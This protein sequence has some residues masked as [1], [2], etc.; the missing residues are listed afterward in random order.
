MTQKQETVKLNAQQRAAVE[1]G[2]GPL[3]IVAGAG[4]GKTRV[5]VERI[6]S[7]LRTV[8]G[9]EPQQI[10]ALTFT[11]R[12]AEQM[13]QRAAERFGEPAR[14]CRF[15]TFHAFCYELLA[16][17]GPVRALDKIDEWI[18]LR[19]HLEELHLDYYFK[20]SDPGR[21][22]HD[23]VDFCSRCH[24]NLVSPSEY[25]DYVE[26]LAARCRE[27]QKSGA[28]SPDCDPEALARQGEVAR[29]FTVLERLQQDQGLISYGAMISRAIRLLDDSPE[30][31]A[32]LQDQYQF[33][34]V[35]EFQDVNT[36]QFE[37]LV[38]LAG[39][40]KNLT[41]VGD[42][43]QA[44]YRFR[45][46]SFASF[47]QFA[48]QFPEHS[49]IVLDR[50]YRSTQ[51]ILTVAG[52]A[53]AF[54]SQDRYLPEKKLIAENDSGPA[55]EMWEF[56]DDAA[57]ADSTAQRIAASVREGARK[58]YSDFAVLYRA[59]LHRARLVQAL[60][61]HGVPFAIQNLAIHRLPII[62]DLIACLRVIGDP[63]DS[64]SLVRLLSHR[65]WSMSP[66]LLIRQCREAR[67]RKRS[68][69]EWIEQ[70]GV[71]GAWPGR[72]AFLEFRNRF[73]A[74]AKVQ[75]LVEWLPLLLTELGAPS[76][77][78]EKRALGAFS[79]FVSQWNREKSASGLLAEFLVYLA[80][81]EEAGGAIVLPDEAPSRRKHTSEAG[82]ASSQLD[83]WAAPP[84]ID[85]RGRVQLMTLHGAKGLEFEHVILWHLVKRA[86][87]T[88]HRRPLIE[89]PPALWKGPLPR[90]DFHIEEERRLFYVGLTRARNA[91]AL[92]TISNARQRPS[93]FLDELQNT[94][95]P[96]LVRKRPVASPS[97][98]IGAARAPASR[99][100]QWI[101]TPMPPATEEFTLSISQIE[102]Y[103]LCP[104]K[105]HFGNQWQIPVPPTPPLTF[106]L[107]MHGAI[108]EVVA[109]IASRSGNLSAAGL[110]E[111]LDRHWPKGGF[112][113]ATQDRKYR[114]LAGDQLA[115]VAKA[116]GGDGFDLLYQEKPFQMR[117]GC[118]RVVGR[119]DQ[120]HRRAGSGVELVEYKTGSPQSQR[121]ADRSYQITLYAEACRQVLALEPSALILYNLTNQE[122]LRTERSGKD[123][124]A[125]EKIIRETAQQILAGQF[126]AQPGYHC[127]HCAFRPICPAQEEVAG[128]A[129]PSPR[130][131]P[132]DQ[133]T[134]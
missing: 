63:A 13:R 107:V 90:G 88:S 124:L 99:L 83:L 1:H 105:F 47:R 35:D 115:G 51:K 87:P 130:L 11:D 89:L 4:T 15:S 81:F 27:A 102:T 117:V 131:V 64:V 18:F 118:C 67:G 30:L 42:D 95:P 44:I 23:L 58:S 119:L 129:E 53:I 60:R 121:D 45:G 112:A 103:L 24:D 20:V 94:P 110:S 116:W 50:N 114:E 12:A 39:S 86:F 91:L 10:L 73:R 38:R 43:D 40:R 78:D 76:S 17:T 2:Q 100:E 106:G 69:S 54:N 6:G 55:V 5:I 85:D 101:A 84:Q 61:R 132:L 126:P 97:V 111:I 52:A 122:A 28:P 71:W 127:R 70:E 22:L 62:R 108:K 48:E 65:R 93:L 26:S 75:K 34:L 125:L 66:D 98:A 19:R 57:A 16:E 113:D 21:F 32:R 9:L 68:L 3:L 109:T 25:S 49:R 72:A 80:Y 7:L 59:H 56:A 36:A 133:T 33:V 128:E 123:F 8:K 77:E 134:K 14:R 96:D 120:L 92:S 29:V 74:V 46:A 79:E 41:V 82:G 37:L 31:L 104:L